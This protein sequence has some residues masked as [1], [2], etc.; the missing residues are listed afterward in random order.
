M[1]GAGDVD[2]GL[3]LNS[4]K[5]TICS[6]CGR[7]VCSSMPKIFFTSGEVIEADGGV[8]VLDAAAI[9]GITLPYSCRSGR[10]CS[11]KCKVISGETEALQ[12]ETGLSDAEKVEGW[13]LSCVRTA[14]T[15]VV[16]EADT[17]G[18]MTL[19]PVKTFPC[20]I[21][22]LAKLAEDVMQVRLRLPPSAQFDFLPGQYIDVIGK[23]NLRRSYSLAKGDFGDKTLELQIRAVQGGAMSAYWF[24]QA[25]DNDL[26][27]LSGP[28]GTF[29]LRESTGKD[30]IF[31][32]TGTGITPI[33]A[34][35]E[36]LP[37]L[38]P[39]KAP[40]SVT[41]LWGGRKLGDLYLDVG[42]MAGNFRYHPVLSRPES[43]WTGATGHIQDVLLAM[44]PDLVNASVYA[45]GSEVMIRD[46]KEALVSAG[47][48]HNRFYSDAF[49][50]SSDAISK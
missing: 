46:A 9:A 40:R 10:C 18:G 48:P 35:L 6:C 39:E 1:L 29:F 30:L 20:R 11:C 25:K 3:S 15:D 12:A 44:R 24:H 36:T 45:C 31:L 41:V 16:L 7:A 50:C 5:Q 43:T 14:K 26:L 27:R 47:L 49:V 34:I 19:P 38:I 33:K 2:R 8:S 42:A 17:L 21:H 13:I 37:A 28:L 32:A 23:N 22:S 4:H